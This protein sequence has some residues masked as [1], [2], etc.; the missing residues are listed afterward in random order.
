MQKLMLLGDTHGNT[1][2]IIDKV[3]PAAKEAEVEWIYQVGDF[4]YWE[5]TFKGKKFLDDVQ[6][7]L[8][9]AGLKLLFIQ[10]NHDKV[11]L[12]EESYPVVD[13]FY[14][15]R[16]SIW[17]APNGTYWEVE[18]KSFVAL[19]GAYSIDKYIRLEDEEAKAQRNCAVSPLRGRYSEDYILKGERAKSAGTYWF[20][21]EEITQVEFDKILSQLKGKKVDVILAH[22]KPFMANPGVKLLPI[23]ECEPNQRNLQKAIN[24]LQPSLFV[25]GHLHIRYTDHVRCGDNNIYTRIEGLGADVPNFNQSRRDWSPDDAWEI[26]ALFED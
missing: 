23:K 5:H 24:V 22:D 26:L 10:G 21:E 1:N 8:V 7:A 11:S 9:K 19:G 16:P 4:G 2:F 25:H 18:G 14:L 20:P 13:G 3:I 15:V 17:Y 6:E 12:I